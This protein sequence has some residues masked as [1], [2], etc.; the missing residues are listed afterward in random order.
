MAFF[1]ARPILLRILILG[2]NK[3]AYGQ[4]DYPMKVIRHL[5]SDPDTLAGAVRVRG[6]RLSV[7]FIL[8]LFEK[9]W[10]EKQILENYPQLTP[11]ILADVFAFAR[12]ALQT[13][14]IISFK[15]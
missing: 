13:E 1:S 6:T 15:P 9:G 12:Q 2:W 14:Q 7:D 3:Y 11:E 5:E 8:E 10:T 4:R